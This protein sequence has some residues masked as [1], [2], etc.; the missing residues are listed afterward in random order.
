MNEF[1]D[2]V[3]KQAQE[4]MKF[5]IQDADNLSKQSG[6]TM[7]ILLTVLGAGTAYG[8]KLFDAQG[9]KSL[10]IAAI[11]FSVY[12][13]LVCAFLVFK[14]L[15]IQAIPPPTNEPENLYKKSMSLDSVREEELRNLQSRINQ[16]VVR[17]DATA[18]WLNCIR[19]LTVASPIVFVLVAFLAAL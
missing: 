9:D 8:I 2:W 4:N 11:V 19:L 7:T 13:L 17:N 16:L 1:I 14:C 12:V 5:R 3:E 18:R 10:F 15:K 6:A